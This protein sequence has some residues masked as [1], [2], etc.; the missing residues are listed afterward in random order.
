M[1]LSNYLSNSTALLGGG[2][3]ASSCCDISAAAAKA[4]F[5]SRHF[6]GFDLAAISIAVWLLLVSFCVLRTP[7]LGRCG[8]PVSLSLFLS[9]SLGD[10]GGDC[11]RW[12]W[13]SMIRATASSRY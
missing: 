12:L 11:Y 7:H 10:G 1:K 8:S 4:F 5:P 2:T 13:R 9:L 3:Y 6:M